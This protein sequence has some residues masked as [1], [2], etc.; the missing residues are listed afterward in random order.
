MGTIRKTPNGKYEARIQLAGFPAKSKTLATEREAKIWVQKQEAMLLSAGTYAD[1]G[2]VTVADAIDAF[3]KS[4]KGKTMDKCVFIPGLAE[5]GSYRVRHLSHEILSE[6]IDKLR[7]ARI[8]DYA[9]GRKHN[10]AHAHRNYSDATVRIFYNALRQALQWHASRN[11][12]QLREGLFKLDEKLPAAWANQRERRV[13]DGEFK[14]LSDALKGMKKRSFSGP[15]LLEFA[16][17]TCMRTQELAYIKWSSISYDGKGMQLRPEEV[18]TKT[19]RTVPLSKRAR[20]IV[21]KLRQETELQKRVCPVRSQED[22]QWIFWEFEGDP[23]SITNHF[24]SAI[25]KAGLKD[26]HFHDL[27]H[28]GISR[29]A[30]RG[31]I[32]MAELMKMSGHTSITTFLR[33]ANLFPNE[34]ADKL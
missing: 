27:R 29:I 34:T 5:L 3:I 15:L 33:Y 17:E 28:E 16:I 7:N 12:Y 4:K 31:K 23:R 32:S 22:Y 6:F 14:A 8:S 19:G 24:A 20:E 26:F 2:I 30:E 25:R 18:K 21:D 11:C 1:P 9:K 10:T 13:L